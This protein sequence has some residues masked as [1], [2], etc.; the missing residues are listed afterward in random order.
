MSKY[1]LEEGI[2]VRVP[3]LIFEDKDS[4]DVE[5]VMF[6]EVRIDQIEED[7]VYLSTLR[8]NDHYDGERFPR[9]LVQAW[10]YKPYFNV[11]SYEEKNVDQKA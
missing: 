1:D 4:S 10:Q 8:D 2:K 9:D 6:F 3:N 5:D 11:S 7:Y